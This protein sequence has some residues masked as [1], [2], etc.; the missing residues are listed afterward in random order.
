MLNGFWKLTWVEI[1]IFLREPMG[2]FASLGIPV[3][4]FLLLGRVFRATNANA[5]ASP[6]DLAERPVIFAAAFIAF[7]TV[8]SL[9]AIITI[10]REGG[11]LTRL[12]ATPQR[13]VTILGA[14]VMVKLL[15]S[16]AALGLLFLAGKRYYGALEV[17]LFSFAGALLLSTLSIVSIGF[18]VA[19]VVRTARFAR[20]LASALLFPMLA[21]SGLFMPID[22][23]PAPWGTVAI[24]LPTTHAVSLLQGVWNGVPWSQHFVEIAALILNFALCSAIASKFFRWE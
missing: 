17:N 21:I 4:V 14:H 23:L 16:V 15:L 2:A 11:I 9:T 3:I 8:T 19:S 13:P 24:A 6:T 20:P 7:T 1:K 10:S 5:A 18:I 22:A 12:R